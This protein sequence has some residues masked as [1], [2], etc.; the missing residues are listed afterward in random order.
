MSEDLTFETKGVQTED[1]LEDMDDKNDSFLKLKSPNS[2]S[3]SKEMILDASESEKKYV[4][5]LLLK[6]FNY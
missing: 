4:K 2:E 5:D 6:Y 1:E 3:R